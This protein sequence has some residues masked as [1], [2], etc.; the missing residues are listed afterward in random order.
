VSVGALVER[1]GWVLGRAHGLFGNPP[2]SGGPSATG[3]SIRLA[4]A[5]DLVR[6]GQGRIEGLSGDFATNYGAFAGGAGPALDELA[7]ADDRLG[8]QLGDA[9]TSDRTG[10]SASGSVVNGAAADT[11]GL[12]PW[13]NTPAGEKALITALR[14]RVTAQQ[15]VVQAYQLRDARMAALLR[16]LAYARR[17]GGPG[18]GFGMPSGGGGFGGLGQSPRSPSTLSGRSGLTAGSQHPQ[19][20]ALTKQRG[21]ARDMPEG[22]G[23]TAVEA[24]LSRRG[25]PYGWGAKGPTSF[26]CSGLTQWSWGQAGVQLG[27]DT[28]AQINEGIPVAP[29]EVRAGD[30]IFPTASFGED[31]RAG[32]GHVQL[33][34]SPTEVI[35]APQPGDVVRVAPMPTAYVARRPVPAG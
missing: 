32:P 26:D 33:A 7:G 3:A 10:R 11:A 2:E 22:P 27:G 9:A 5:G 18:G 29:G 25:S 15:K 28:Y 8:N 24:A 13:S 12:G 14:A 1:V 21:I 30:L 20:A 34:I 6:A 4:G 16:A 19:T 23:G 35:H 31:G 17:G